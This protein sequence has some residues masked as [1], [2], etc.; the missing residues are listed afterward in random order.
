MCLDTKGW[1]FI[2]DE[3]PPEDEYVLVNHDGWIG[4]SRITDGEWDTGEKTWRY[5]IFKGKERMGTR[6]SAQYWKRL[7]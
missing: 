6:A 5:P 2:D 7:H 3:Q 4:I 1:I